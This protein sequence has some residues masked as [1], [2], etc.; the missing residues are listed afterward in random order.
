[1]RRAALALALSLYSASATVEIL[2][3]NERSWSVKLPMV[4]QEGFRDKK[5]KLEGQTGWSL[6][7]GSQDDLQ[8]DLAFIVTTTDDGVDPTE[9]IEDDDIIIVSWVIPTNQHT[10]EVANYEGGVMQFYKGAGSE[11]SDTEDDDEDEEEADEDADDNDDEEQYI[12]TAPSKKWTL[13]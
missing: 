11:I 8:M 2:Q 12:F 3:E 5:W 9:T 7:S 6:T 1:M 13:T 4:Q 10:E